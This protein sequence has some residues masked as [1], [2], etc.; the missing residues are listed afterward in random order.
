M[1]ILGISALQSTILFC[2]YDHEPCKQLGDELVLKEKQT[3]TYLPKVIL[4]DTSNGIH[5]SHLGSRTN[6][7]HSN[8]SSDFDD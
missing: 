6:Q 2:E 1:Y 5:A 4:L 7:L 3:R 8:M